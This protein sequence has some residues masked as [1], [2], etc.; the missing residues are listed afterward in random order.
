MLNS[1]D[2]LSLILQMISLEIL[3]KDYNNTDLMQELQIQDEKY[4]K[5]IIEQNKQIIELLKG[6]TDESRTK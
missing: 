2:N 5:K 1:V 6:G 4:F 3:L